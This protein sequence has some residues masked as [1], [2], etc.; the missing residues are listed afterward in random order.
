MTSQWSRSLLSD[1]RRWCRT[2][3]APSVGITSICVSLYW[4]VRGLA[5]ASTSFFLAST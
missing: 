5:T 3:N 1:K 2:T 4:F